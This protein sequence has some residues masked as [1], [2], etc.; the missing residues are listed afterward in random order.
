MALYVHVYVYIYVYVC[1][2]IIHV[3]V[4]DGNNGIIT[5][6]FTQRILVNINISKIYLTI[7]TLTSLSLNGVLE[8][9]LS[10]LNYLM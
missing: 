6:I 10:E 3:P 4:H 1:I 5:L 2:Y 9:T 8:Y 7:Q